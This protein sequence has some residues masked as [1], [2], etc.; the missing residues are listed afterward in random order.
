MGT[1][2]N[3]NNS[4]N[5]PQKL[6]NKTLTQQIFHPGLFNRPRSQSLSDCTNDQNSHNPGV[7][8]QPNQNPAPTWTDVPNRK[9]LRNSP[10]NDR[11]PKQTKLGTYWLSQPLPTTNSFDGLE[12]DVEEIQSQEAE[13]Q[14]KPPPIFI[15]KVTNI[16]PLTQL[17]EDT[18]EGSFEIK[19][20]PK[21]QVKIQPTSKEAYKTIVK[22]LDVKGTEYYTYKPKHERSFKVIL[23]HMHPSTDTDEIKAALL[24]LDHSV[25]NIWNMKQ[26]ST[27]NPLHLFVVELQPKS[28]NKDI[29]NIKNLLHC[30]IK[31]E[32]PRPKRT[33]PQCSNCLAYGHTKTYCRRSPR[34]I[35]CAGNHASIDCS[36][37]ERSENVKCALCDGNHPANYKGCSVYKDLQKQ[38]YPPLRYKN[39]TQT[40]TATNVPKPQPLIT[41]QRRSS[42]DAT[43]QPQSQIYSVHRNYATV[44]S[45]SPAQAANNKPPRAVPIN[46]PTP[47]PPQPKLS[48]KQPQNMP[49]DDSGDFK[50]LMEM[51]KQMMQQMNTMTNLL[52]SFMTEIRTQHTHQGTSQDFIQGGGNRPCLPPRG[53]THT[54]R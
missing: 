44:A 24:D 15:D 8:T 49:R 33:I 10:E 14:P 4:I 30:R 41:N 45:S 26:A 36:R 54:N 50:E 7:S 37:K 20:L 21:N 18:V 23:K 17:L 51:F 46:K 52:L 25:T 11:R 16:R 38:K 34:C 5:L 28:N 31:F 3:E 40:N 39:P 48:Q 35:K 32:P 22:E 9:R 6:A 2:I 13:K 53:Y 12:T 27:N 29:Y 1:N 43:C 47:E 42:L 19:I